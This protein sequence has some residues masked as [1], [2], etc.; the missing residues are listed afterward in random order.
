MFAMKIYP[1]VS[2][3]IGTGGPETDAIKIEENSLGILFSF[4]LL[5]KRANVRPLESE[6]TRHSTLEFAC[7]NFEMASLL[8]S[9]DNEILSDRGRQSTHTVLTRPIPQNSPNSYIYVCTRIFQK[10]YK[11][12]SPR[13]PAKNRVHKVIYIYI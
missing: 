11:R 9:Q 6:E 4:L 12:K 8:R 3:Y 1:M 2:A 5:E 7:N 10:S 13:N